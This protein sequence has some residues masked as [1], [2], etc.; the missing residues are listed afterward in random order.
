MY[1]NGY[2]CYTPCYSGLNYG[3][4]AGY[5]GGCGFAFILVLFIFLAI[6]FMTLRQSKN[7]KEMPR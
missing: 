6:I 2:N 3:G 1:N 4:G 7:V 5:G